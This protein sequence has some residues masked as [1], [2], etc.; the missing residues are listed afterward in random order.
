MFCF[1]M[2]GQGLPDNCF[3][4]AKTT[5]LLPSPDSESSEESSRPTARK[6]HKNRKC[7]LG[8]ESKFNTVQCGLVFEIALLC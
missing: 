6:G 3:G 4:V 7:E 5:T 1:V 2:G 8:R